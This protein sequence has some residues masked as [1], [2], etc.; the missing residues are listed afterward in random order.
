[1]SQNVNTLLKAATNDGV[2]GAQSL[3]ALNAIDPGQE[4]QQGLGIDIGD[5]TASEVILVTL[6]IDDSG[7]IRMVGGNSDAV[8][9]GHN[10]ILAALKA[11]KQKDSIIVCTRYFTG[12][13]GQNVLYPYCKLQDAVEM[14]PQNYNPQGSTPLYKQSLITLG[15]VVSKAQEFEDNGVS[16]RSVTAIVTDGADTDGGATARD[17][18]KIVTDMRRAEKHIVCGMGIADGSTD[19]VQVFESMGIPANQVLTPS[20]DPSSIR[21]AFNAISQSAVRASQNAQSFSQMSKANLGG[22][23]G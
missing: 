15:L 12:T 8:R 22:F 10:G 11:T 14:T 4:I 2:L 23:G 13:G 9:Q 7:S 3:Q 6:L 1:M 18:S 19:F 17:V 16:V 20:N 5:V 21:R